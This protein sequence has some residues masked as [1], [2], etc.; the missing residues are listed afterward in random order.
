MAYAAL[1]NTRLIESWII[2]A[3]WRE[4]QFFSCFYTTFHSKGRQSEVVYEM[5]KLD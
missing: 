2:V 3:Q 1:A 5:G 4:T